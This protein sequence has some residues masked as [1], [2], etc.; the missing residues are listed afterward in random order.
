MKIKMLTLWSHPEG[1]HKPG[2]I[3]NLPQKIAAELVASRA[4]VEVKDDPAAAADAKAEEE[5]KQAA[6]EDPAKPEPK[7]ATSRRGKAADGDGDAGAEGDG[8]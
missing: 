1:T 5:A 6:A 3:V 7:K 8:K 2:D 4:A